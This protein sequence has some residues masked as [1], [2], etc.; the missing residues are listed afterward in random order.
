M[1]FSADGIVS[2]VFGQI[3]TTV[4][5]A[6]KSCSRIRQMHTHRA[7]VD[8]AS[9][10]VVLSG[11]AHG[12]MSAL[13]NSRFINDAQGFQIRM[14]RRDKLL[15]TIPE[16][17]FVPLDGFQQTLQSSRSYAK[18][19]RD[20]FAVLSLQS[21]QLPFDIR[22]HQGSSVTPAEAVRE[23]LEKQNLPST[24]TGNLLECH[25]DDPP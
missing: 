11:N 19:Q 18:L 8:L 5:Q 9:V 1:F 16:F 24:H 12:V 22:Q 14:F 21:R 7:V 6:S 2:P 25:P 13:R 15:A 20:G 4:Q 10:A 23:Q 17:G 3:E